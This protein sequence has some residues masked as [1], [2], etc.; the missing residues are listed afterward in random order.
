MYYSITGEI[1]TNQELDREK[2]SVYEVPVTA[3]DGGGRTGFAL[4]KI[5]VGD[6]NDNAPKFLLSEYSVCI[7]SNLT[8]NSPFLKASRETVLLI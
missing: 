7:Y 5:T 2:C 4:V 8:I 1:S 3:T 6:I